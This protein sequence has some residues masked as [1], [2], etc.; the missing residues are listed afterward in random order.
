M[1]Q[2]GCK[3]KR[4]CTHVKDPK[5][6][7]PNLILSPRRK[8]RMQLVEGGWRCCSIGQTI[9]K[10]RRSDSD[11]LCIEIGEGCRTASLGP[12]KI[13]SWNFHR[14]ENTREI[15]ALRDLIAREEPKLVLLQE[16]NLKANV[17]ATKKFGFN[18]LTFLAMDSEGR[19][20]GFWLSCGKQTYVS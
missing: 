2:T 16:T 12:M 9:V 14:L 13:R 17:M 4:I 11:E 18:F 1:E 10:G 15:W 3:W 7:F 8:K 5:P 20:K 19:R 6:N